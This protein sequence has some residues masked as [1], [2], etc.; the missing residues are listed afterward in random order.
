[1]KT[2]TTST[3]KNRKLS[4]LALALALSAG[5]IGG[6]MTFAA[7]T[8]PAFAQAAGKGG[9]GAGGAGGEAD[10][11]VMNPNEPRTHARRPNLP[12]VV[13]V[14]PPRPNCQQNTDGVELKNCRYT[15]RPTPR[16]V[17]I[18]GFANCAVVHQA[19][20]GQFYCVRPM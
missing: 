18:N 6:M 14:A 16:I 17:S 9:G 7:T 8:E 11:N 10:P 1:M 15:Q 12:P 4:H 2:A 13:R 20:S 19:P 3:I 5:T